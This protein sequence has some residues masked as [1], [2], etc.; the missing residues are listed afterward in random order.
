MLLC[1][2]EDDKWK[3]S[4]RVNNDE[5]QKRQSTGSIS[6]RNNCLGTGYNHHLH[7]HEGSV[8]YLIDNINNYEKAPGQGVQ[9]AAFS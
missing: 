6:Y 3:I 9:A 2:G 1:Y 8:W 4:L 5:I 7:V